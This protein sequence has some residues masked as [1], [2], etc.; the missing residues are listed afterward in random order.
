MM[1]EVPAIRVRLTILPQN[2]VAAYLQQFTEK[3]YGG[4]LLALALHGLAAQ[5]A[6]AGGSLGTPFPAMAA[7]NPLSPDPLPDSHV[8][9][10]VNDLSRPDPLPADFGGLEQLAQKL[11]ADA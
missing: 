11:M 10:R 4:A 1:T 2:P 7:T 5:A 3:Q 6:L 8:I 9:S